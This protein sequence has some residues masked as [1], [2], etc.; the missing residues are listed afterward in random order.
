LLPFSKKILTNRVPETLLDNLVADLQWIGIDMSAMYPISCI[1]L[2][3]GEI[4]KL[5][6]SSVILIPSASSPTS[7]HTSQPRAFL[8]YEGKSRPDFI[9]N[10]RGSSCRV[11]FIM[12]PF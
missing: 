7:L 9:I 6:C 4:C 10:V 5:S 8:N 1:N 11:S 3:N 12:L 2:I